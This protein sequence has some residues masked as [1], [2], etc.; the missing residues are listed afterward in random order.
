MSWPV[1]V[2]VWGGGGQKVAGA[3]AGRHT[4]FAVA[5]ATTLFV[6]VVN[7]ASNRAAAQS[8]TPV[9]RCCTPPSSPPAPHTCSHAHSPPQPPPLETHTCVRVLLLYG[10]PQP[11][12]YPPTC[13]SVLLLY[14]RILPSLLPTTTW[15]SP[16]VAMQL[17][18]VPRAK[19]LPPVHCTMGDAS[20]ASC[21]VHK[22]QPMTTDTSIGV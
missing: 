19:S 15:P 14:S 9:P 8:M 22:H 20:P 11:H 12:P 21:V 16:L 5:G 7:L 13:V 3:T 4:W 6:T 1:G 2:C 10:P 17:K 18:L